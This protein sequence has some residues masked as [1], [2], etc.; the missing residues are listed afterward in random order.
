[1]LTGS[2]GPASETRLEDMNVNPPMPPVP[3]S[4][5]DSGA[6]VVP[7]PVAES[8]WVSVPGVLRRL[9]RDTAFILVALPA[10][11]LSFTVL[12]TG[13]SLAAALLVTVIGVPVA[14]ATLAAGA[15]FASLERWRLGLR[16]TPLEPRRRPLRGG[17]G[18]G[19]RGMLGALSDRDRWADV[20]HGISILP[21]AII[22]WSVVITWWVGALGG[23]T[24]WFWLTPIFIT[25][26]LVP[27]RLR[28]LIAGNPL[29]YVVRAYRRALLSYQAPDLGDLGIL[30]LSAM[31]TFILGGLFFRHMKRGFADVL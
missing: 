6:T 14:V 18:L 16:G 22:T 4:A 5:V 30:A 19:L 10:A 17:H 13:L 7:V 12:V 11:L 29:A 8:R 2:T 23:L 25:E 15:G 21:L 1:M 31:V 27:G 24:F 28:F 26:D 9:G 20:L 3:V